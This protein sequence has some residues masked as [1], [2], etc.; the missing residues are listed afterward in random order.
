[1][2]GKLGTLEPE[3]LSQADELVDRIDVELVRR[4]LS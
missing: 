2:I 4:C 1:V 3:R